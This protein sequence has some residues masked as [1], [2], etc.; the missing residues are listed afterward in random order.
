MLDIMHVVRICCPCTK[1]CK[2]HSTNSKIDS[3][4]ETQMLG[5]K[6]VLQKRTDL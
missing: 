1:I 5:A 6:H 3:D 2:K 4:V